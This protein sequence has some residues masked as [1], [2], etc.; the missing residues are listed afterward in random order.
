MISDERIMG[1]VEGEGCFSIFIQ[2]DIDRRL[3]KTGRKN[4][5]K[6][7]SMGFRINPSFRVTQV[8][9]DCQILYRIK[10]TLGV[11]KVYSETR[12]GNYNLTLTVG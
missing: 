8:K 6:S 10:K 12:T 7:P 3:R 1:F 11:G 2:K 4:N 9:E 5:R